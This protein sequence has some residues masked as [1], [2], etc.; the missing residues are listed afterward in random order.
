M[1]LQLFSNELQKLTRD[2][3]RS[4]FPFN[5]PSPASYY[6]TLQQAPIVISSINDMYLCD[7]FP[8]YICNVLKCLFPP[9]SR[10]DHIKI[11]FA[12]F[13][14]E[15]TLILSTWTKK[16]NEEKISYVS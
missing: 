5:F 13:I 3:S 4:F 2:Q 11:I 16:N 1:K 7:N 6:V 12:S 9:T 15:I 10:N 8:N 14:G